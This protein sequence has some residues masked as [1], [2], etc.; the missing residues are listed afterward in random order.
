M[1]ITQSVSRSIRK[2]EAIATLYFVWRSEAMTKALMIRNEQKVAAA[3]AVM[4]RMLACTLFVGI[5]DGTPSL[6][7]E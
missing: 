5:L 3:A 6:C 7:R 4:A 2:W 1:M